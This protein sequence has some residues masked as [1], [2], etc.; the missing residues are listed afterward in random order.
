MCVV[1]LL[2]LQPGEKNVFKKVPILH[3]ESLRASVSFVLLFCFEFQAQGCLG[4]NWVIFVA[5]LFTQ[6]SLCLISSV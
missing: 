4:I 2:F 3:Y 5:V 6:L 1:M